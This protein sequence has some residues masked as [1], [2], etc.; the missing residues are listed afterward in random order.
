ME[1]EYH[2]ILI[3]PPLTV[4]FP[5]TLHPLV[6]STLAFRMMV[7]ILVVCGYIL[8]LAGHLILSKHLSTSKWFKLCVDSRLVPSAAPSGGRP[9]GRGAEAAARACGRAADE[10]AAAAMAVDDAEEKEEDDVK[11]FKSSWTASPISRSP[12][13]SQ[14]PFP[15]PYGQV[16]LETSNHDPVSLDLAP[17]DVTRAHALPPAILPR[18]QRMIEGA[19]RAHAEAVAARSGD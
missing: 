12:S 8:L 6:I 2:K 19:S 18:L 1:L 5:A 9:I 3:S 16:R 10:S 13:S 4:L 7:G 11:A 14:R 17:A 15:T